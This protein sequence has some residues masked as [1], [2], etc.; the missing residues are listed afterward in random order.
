MQYGQQ[1]RETEAASHFAPQS[2]FRLNSL[3]VSKATGLMPGFEYLLFSL[4]DS[5]NLMKSLDILVYLG[6][7]MIMAM[8]VM[9]VS[10]PVSML[11]WLSHLMFF[12]NPA[13]PKLD[14]NGPSFCSAVAEQSCRF[15]GGKPC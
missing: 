1:S 9:L 2:L 3:P 12:D 7:L 10:M 15:R 4:P 6:M 8:L 5:C 14:N 11:V 13:L